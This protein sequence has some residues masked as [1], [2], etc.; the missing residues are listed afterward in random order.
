MSH[1]GA[2]GTVPHP[3]SMNHSPSAASAQPT[4]A[5]SIDAIPVQSFNA[6]KMRRHSLPNSEQSSSHSNQHPHSARAAASITNASVAQVGSVAISVPVPVPPPRPP[7]GSRSAR[8][9]SSARAARAQRKANTPGAAANERTAHCVRCAGPLRDQSA[10]HA[11]ALTSTTESSDTIGGGSQ[12]EE[13]SADDTSINTSRLCASCK[14]HDASIA[15]P[16]SQPNSGRERF[17]ESLP[18]SSNQPKPK[19]GPSPSIPTFLSA[20]ASARD[21]RSL[22]LA[23]T[24]SEKVC[25]SRGV[26][27]ELLRRQLAQHLLDRE[28]L[29]TTNQESQRSIMQLR[30]QLTARNDA[31]LELREQI[32]IALTERHQVELE[33]VHLRS[34]YRQLQTAFGAMHEEIAQL[35]KEHQQNIRERMDMKTRMEEM[36]KRASTTADAHNTLMP[37]YRELQDAHTRLVSELDEARSVHSA[38]NEEVETRLRPELDELRR[39]VADLRCELQAR[40]EELGEIRPQ[41]SSL[42]SQL[43]SANT[44]KSELT[45]QL[46]TA[47]ERLANLE[48]EASFYRSKL[49]NQTLQHARKEIQDDCILREAT[50]KQQR[51]ERQFQTQL[52]RAEQAEEKVDVLQNEL[53]QLYETKTQLEKDLSSERVAHASLRERHQQLQY[54]QSSTQRALDSERKTSSTL[55]SQLETTSNARDE[56]MSNAARIRQQLEELST[57]HA[58]QLE[59]MAKL[60]KEHNKSQDTLVRMEREHSQ[61][62]TGWHER[63]RQLVAQL[64]ELRASFSTTRSQLSA[65]QS[66]RRASAAEGRATRNRVAT[67]EEKWRRTKERLEQL[68]NV[69]ERCTTKAAELL[70]ANKQIHA[71]E[72]RNTSLQRKLQDANETV[73]NSAAQI[74]KMQKQLSSESA[75]HLQLATSYSNL[76]SEHAR[77]SSSH[78]TL[79]ARCDSLQKEL[80]ATSEKLAQRSRELTRLRANLSE[81]SNE[82]RHVKQLWHEAQDRADRAQKAQTT[83]EQ[84]L[85]SMRQEHERIQQLVVQKEMR[86]RELKQQLDGVKLVGQQEDQRPS[87]PEMPKSQE[88][89]EATQDADAEVAADKP[90]HDTEAQPNHLIQAKADLQRE[91]A[92]SEEHVQRLSEEI[93]SLRHLP[94]VQESELSSLRAQLESEMSKHAQVEQELATMKSSFESCQKEL[95]SSQLLVKLLQDERKANEPKVAFY[96]LYHKPPSTPDDKTRIHPDIL[97]EIVEGLKKKCDEQS[98]TINE[99]ASKVRQLMSQQNNNVTTTTTTM[100]QQT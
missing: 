63:E 25:L 14:L 74:T 15:T 13:K 36:Q 71:L 19:H 89:E 23:L 8:G 80:S 37:Q 48:Q 65:L 81:R 35:Q 6:L 2:T 78:T 82:V 5:N 57:E 99:L 62:Q 52:E 53:R 42:Q 31:Q 88:E 98:N 22:S 79:R 26:E 84:K 56:A 96:N 66:E 100:V 3:S 75:S 32:D 4:A 55:K 83:F 44:S 17:N 10:F 92:A 33:H 20:L 12:T 38:L 7:S 76:Q 16:A 24:Q 11:W 39:T 47:L 51:V 97:E 61:T 29:E 50:L 69:H 77:L 18:F 60:R 41:L 91:L 73:S 40:D 67:L 95:Y 87:A 1:R 90:S 43:T 68:N 64:S 49:D 86:N 9:S 30:Q 58:T 85:E 54:A 70:T 21:V 46:D 34:E 27:I 28:K 94:S 45:G 72:T 93:G 59:E